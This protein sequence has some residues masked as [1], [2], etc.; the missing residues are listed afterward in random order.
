MVSQIVVSVA[1]AICV[2]WITGAYLSDGAK[3]DAAA[4]ATDTAPPATKVSSSGS[5]PAL[6]VDIIADVPDGVS[7]G[8][9][10]FPGAPAGVR[11]EA[12]QQ[13][14]AK[15]ETSE[16]RR[17]RFLGIPIPFTSTANDVAEEQVSG[18]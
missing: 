9:E 11:P 12:L 14:A 17:R 5:L 18:G 2:A 6:D 4:L 8:E 13:A 1:A 10:I 3:P 7:P 16:P 15:Q